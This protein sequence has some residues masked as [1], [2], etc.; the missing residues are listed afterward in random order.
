MARPQSYPINWRLAILLVAFCGQRALAVE[1][2]GYVP[3]YRMNSSYTSTVLPAQLVMLDE[4]RY[5]GLTAGSNGSVSTLDGASL[6]SHLHRIETI[7]EAIAAMPAANRPRLSITLGGAGEA[8][9][10]A[11]IAAN[12]ALRNTFAQNIQSLMVQTGAVSVD[13]DWEHPVGAAQFGQYSAMLQRIKQEVGMDRR[14]YAT[15]DP[16]IYIPLDVFNGPNAIDGI[17]LMTYELAWWANDPADHNRGEHSLPE[18]AE[19]SLDAWTLPVSSPN[20]RPWVFATWGRA[21]PSEKLG[22]GLPFFGRVVGTSQNPQGGAAYTYAELVNGGSTTNGNDYAYLGQ[23]V[24]ITGPELAAER[25]QFAHER[26]LDNVII[27]ELAQD[28]HPS[29]ANS[30]LRAAYGMKQS[31]AVLSGDFN[32]D[33]SVDAADYVAW[34]KQ[35]GT[36]DGYE[37]WRSNFGESSVNGGGVAARQFVPEPKALLLLIVN[38]L[39]GAMMRPFRGLATHGPA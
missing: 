7:S 8:A 23:N 22:I 13:I 39:M 14:V 21:A 28:L 5:F 16:T 17:S 10:F 4:V 24:W 37:Q 19:V 33:G 32:D 29:H 12:S 9:S 30:L 6:N 11:G 1:L 35:G 18:Y 38:Y 26:G 20:Q 2:I 31:L 34:R 25:V 15:I 27:W 3:Y 36:P